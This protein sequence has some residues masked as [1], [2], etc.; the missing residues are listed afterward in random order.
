M[1]ETVQERRFNVRWYVHLTH[2]RG[3][4]IRGRTFFVSSTGALFF[5][6]VRYR[7][8]DTLDMEIFIEPTRSIRCTAKIVADGS[9]FQ[10]EFQRFSGEDHK[11]LND[12]LLD[13][14]RKNV[15]KRK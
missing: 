12:T 11:L 2:P 14:H 9:P 3:G 7:V 15:K 4:M 8:G 6:P 13:V 1:E 5:A 10:A